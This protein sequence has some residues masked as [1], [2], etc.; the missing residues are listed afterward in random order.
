MKRSQDCTEAIERLPWLLNGSLG[1]AERV[2]V[3]DHLRACSSCRAELAAVREAWT[4]FNAHPPSR[5][6]VAFALGDRVESARDLKAHVEGCSICTEDVDLVRANGKIETLAWPRTTDSPTMWRRSFF[7]A[8]AVAMVTIAVSLFAWTSIKGPTSDPGRIADLNAQI[9]RLRNVTT[10]LETERTELL[11][12][13][14]NGER[15]LGELKDQ[16]GSLKGPSLNIPVLEL[17][18]TD[19]LTRGV[20]QDTVVDRSNDAVALI[21]AT[22]IDK[23]FEELRVTVAGPDGSVVHTETGLVLHPSNDFT[24]LLPVASLPGGRLTLSIEGLE[25]GRWTS[26]EKYNLLIED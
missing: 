10:H 7:A 9:E 22:G 20:P 4:L 24:L 15:L 18:P 19:F 17:F 5:D 26:L 6:L 13:I 8:A 1:D 3:L 16:L 23:D 12:K 11:Q 14:G 21:L 2:T 25:D